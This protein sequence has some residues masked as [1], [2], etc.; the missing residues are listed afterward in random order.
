MHPSII[1]TIENLGIIRIHRIRIVAKKSCQK[2]GAIWREC[3][4]TDKYVYGKVYPSRYSI[5][6]RVV[7]ATLKLLMEPL[8]DLC[9]STNGYGFR[10]GRNQRQAWVFDAVTI[11]LLG[12]DSQ[13]CQILD[14]AV[15]VFK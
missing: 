12:S 2:K 9:F 5:R 4:V 6:D 10:P 8:I 3:S 7:Q 1:L 11:R 13:Q 14:I 15:G